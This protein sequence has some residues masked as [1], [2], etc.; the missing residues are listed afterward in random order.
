[1]AILLATRQT[2]GL[3]RYLITFSSSAALPGTSD[4]R[5]SRREI[6]VKRK[7]RFGSKAAH[8]RQAAHRASA[9]ALLIVSP[10]EAILQQATDLGIEVI[11]K[12]VAPV[13]L[14]MS[15]ARAPSGTILPGRISCA[16]RQSPG[17]PQCVLV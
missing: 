1:M 10:T 12:P 11:E 6:G 17:R 3:N 4:R 15:L 7:V 14:R 13:V 9:F 16:G 5:A 8:R 2:N